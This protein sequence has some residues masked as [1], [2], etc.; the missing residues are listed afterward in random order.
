M[1]GDFKLKKNI[2]KVKIFQGCKV[3]KA[4]SN[5]LF[6]QQLAA[7]TTQQTRYVKPMPI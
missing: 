4:T 3:Y 1:N 5:Q 6:W 7:L 2:E